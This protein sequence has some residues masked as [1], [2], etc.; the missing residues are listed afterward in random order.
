MKIGFKSYC[1]SEKEKRKREGEREVK[2]EY[3]EN[4]KNKTELFNL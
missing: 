3:T 4:G 1:W 2:K